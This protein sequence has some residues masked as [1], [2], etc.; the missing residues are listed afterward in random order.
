MLVACSDPA[1]TPCGDEGRFVDDA[2]VYEGSAASRVE[3]PSEYPVEHRVAGA[4][5]CTRNEDVPPGV[6]AS[7]DAACAP[8]AMPDADAAIDAAI[9]APD[10]EVPD[11]PDADAPAPGTIGAPCLDDDDCR[12]CLECDSRYECVARDDGD[13][14]PRCGR[15]GCEGRYLY[16]SA[17][18][19]YAARALGTDERTCL[20]GA[21]FEGPDACV[22]RGEVIEPTCRVS[23]CLEIPAPGTCRGAMGPSCIPTPP[24]AG[25]TRGT[26]LELG[27]LSSESDI[28]ASWSLDS[29]DD[30]YVGLPDGGDIV[31]DGRHYASCATLLLGPPTYVTGFSV[32]MSR[33]N[34]VCGEVAATSG[35]DPVVDVLARSP[36]SP[37]RYLSS[38]PLRSVTVETIGLSAQSILDGIVVCKTRG[39]G[40]GLDVRV[41]RIDVGTCPR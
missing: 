15:L 37:P 29:A 20:A 41:E 18:A 35:P 9:D 19:C 16:Y 38:L 27:C 33:A 25:F 8:D 32:A 13:A 1:P 36:E 34:G 2:C 3:C 39:T 6:C 11:A 24:A 22:L 23:A 4:T 40:N 10:A 21:C 7:L 12:P 30:E 14:D 17:G 28:D 26:S 5:V 31:H